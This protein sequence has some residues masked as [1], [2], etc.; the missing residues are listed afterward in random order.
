MRGGYV[1]IQSFLRELELEEKKGRRT[2]TSWT[3]ESDT[4]QSMILVPA[5]KQ[6]RGGLNIVNYCDTG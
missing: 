5:I 1:N 6:P 2:F 3:S 4:G